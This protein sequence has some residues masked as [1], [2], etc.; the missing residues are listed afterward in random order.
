[1][2]SFLGDGEVSGYL[3]TP[4]TTPEPPSSL[5][6]ALCL[7]ALFAIAYRRK[8][9][10]AVIVR[11]RDLEEISE[12]GRG[13]VSGIAEPTEIVR[14]FPIKRSPS[15][16]AYVLHRRRDARKQGEGA[17]HVANV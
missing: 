3:A 11:Q 5:T 2:G 9:A 6:L 13:G 12:P 16:K 4:A 1:V 10:R 7:V 15:H 8:G 14:Y 17:S